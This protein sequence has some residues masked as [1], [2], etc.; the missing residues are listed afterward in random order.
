MR[1]ARSAFIGSAVL[2]LTSLGVGGCIEEKLAPTPP[3][4]VLEQPA[5]PPTIINEPA[6]T[7]VTPPA[8][9]QVRSYERSES[10]MSSDSGMGPFDR[11]KNSSYEKKTFKEESTY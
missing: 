7:I 5:P 10:T 8:Q 2:V 6:P 11:D 3:P 1:L 9:P 4:I